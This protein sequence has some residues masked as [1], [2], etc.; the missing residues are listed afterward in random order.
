[1]G[2]TDQS[3]TVTSNGSTVSYSS[4]SGGILQN[5]EY[6]YLSAGCTGD[7]FHF[8][9]R[10]GKT[11]SD[12][13]IGIAPIWDNVTGTTVSGSFFFGKSEGSSIDI[14]RTLYYPEA[15]NGVLA[16]RT[17]TDPGGDFFTINTKLKKFVATG[18]TF[19]TVF[20]TPFSYRI[21]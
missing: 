21:E 11:F 20:T 19:T 17:V 18:K 16:C 12:S 6:I 5:A 13:A 2:V 8:A 15:N 14:P 4:V 7:K 9:E 1:M 10:G 3:V